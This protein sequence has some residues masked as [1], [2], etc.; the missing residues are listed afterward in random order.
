[1][2]RLLELC[3]IRSPKHI[4]CGLLWYHVYLTKPPFGLAC[5]FR[6]ITEKSCPGAL[7]A[8]HF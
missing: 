7:G 3:K 5:P 2:F 6:S 1:M 4:A 8:G